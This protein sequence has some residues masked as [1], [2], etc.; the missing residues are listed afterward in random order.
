ME[1][2][3]IACEE[4]INYLRSVAPAPDRPEE[5]TQRIIARIERME[6]NK[7]KRIVVRVT[8]WL[9]GVAAGLLLGLLL[10][11]TVQP[12]LV[13]SSG[14]KVAMQTEITVNM[15]CRKT[16]IAERM[17]EKLERKSRKEQIYSACL[18][19]LSAPAK[20]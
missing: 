10:F 14:D 5:L 1:S 7:R 19:K 11:E 20:E 3:K 2:K 18:S 12:A 4:L 8:G 9:S 16:D 13:R 15:E 17:K 6:K